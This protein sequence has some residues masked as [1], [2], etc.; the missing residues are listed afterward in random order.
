MGDAFFDLDRSDIRDDAKAAVQKDADWLKRWTSTKVMIEGHCDERGTAEYNL[1]LG[2]RRAQA[3]RDYLVSLGVAA[4]RV[5]TV[6]K[7]KEQPF[8]DDKNESCWQQNR[9]GHFVIT[10]K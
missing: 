3:V 10:A 9:R 4:A 6:S 8:C 7:G 5:Q 2:E 1:A